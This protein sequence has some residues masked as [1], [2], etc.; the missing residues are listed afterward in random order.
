MHIVTCFSL[1][2]GVGKTTLSLNLAS[3]SARLGQRL[4][5][6]DLDPRGDATRALL[7]NKTPGPT[8]TTWLQG[9]APFESVRH[10][11]RVSGVELIPADPAAP[12]QITTRPW[13]EALRPLVHA[14]QTASGIDLIVIDTHN[15]RDIYAALAI[16]ACNALLIPH[17]PGTFSLDAVIATMQIVLDMQKEIDHKIPALGTVFN[18]FN[19]TDAT[20]VTAFDTAMRRFRYHTLPYVIPDRRS[21]REDDDG[22]PAVERRRGQVPAFYRAIL[23]WLYGRWRE[24]PPW[25]VPASHDEQALVTF[26]E[27]DRG[28]NP[29]I[30]TR[31]AGMLADDVVRA[32]A[33]VAT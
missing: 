28:L 14:L 29:V 16:C 19:R 12:T 33:R 15:S 11:T 30:R 6:L 9:R 18:R 8:V 24:S 23:R 7:D 20:A 13:R 31:V 3:V 26:L 25:R 17:T 10:P 27:K 2:G 4:L 1:K 32:L 5:F 21:L 22:L